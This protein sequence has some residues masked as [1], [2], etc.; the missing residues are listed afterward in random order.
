MNQF[1][2]LHL[3]NDCLFAMRLFIAQFFF[4]PSSP[5]PDNDRFFL[6]A[7]PISLGKCIIH[8]KLSQRKSAITVL[9]GCVFR[10]KDTHPL[11]PG[12]RSSI[13]EF[14]NAIISRNA[15]QIRDPLKKTAKTRPAQPNMVVLGCRKQITSKVSGD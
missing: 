13:L 4:A 5:M 1:C 7:E 6:C 2:I 8:Y 15:V 3:M 11:R 12:A 9:S 10:N 14:L